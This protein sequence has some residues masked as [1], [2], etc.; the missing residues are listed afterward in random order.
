MKSNWNWRIYLLLNLLYFFGKLIFNCLI[1]RRL[2]KL[3]KSLNFN[4][5]LHIYLIIKFFDIF[6]FL[7]PTLHPHYK[8][9]YI[10]NNLSMHFLTKLI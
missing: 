1:P 7:M 3:K 8:L 10:L 6:Y 2:F 4:H 5:F 9:P